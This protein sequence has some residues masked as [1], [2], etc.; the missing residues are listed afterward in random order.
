MDM[1]SNGRVEPA[2]EFAPQVSRDTIIGDSIKEGWEA[3]KSRPGILIGM[4]V[5]M[6]FL[7]GIVTAILNGLFSDNVV[8]LQTSQQAWYLIANCFTAGYAF[9]ALKIIRG[10]EA[11]FGLLFSG[12]NKFV[13]ILIGGIL[14]AIGA[15]LG[16]VLLIVPGIIISMG[17]SQWMLMVMDR[18]VDG[19]EALKLSWQIMNGYKWKYFLMGMLLVLI[20]VLGALALL[21]GLL[22]TVPL[23]IAAGSAFYNRLLAL[24]SLPDKQI[25]EVLER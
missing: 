5:V 24:N 19:V 4:L 13:P 12:F 18:N 1:E 23:S 25:E 11:E 9:A 7:H 10:E 21:I 20:N 6:V 17:W 8:V 3:F 16:F 14:F 2:M 22:V 15:V